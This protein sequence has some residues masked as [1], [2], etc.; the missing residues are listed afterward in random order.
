M[1]G[2]RIG[3]SLYVT[4]LAT[5]FEML[6]KLAFLSEKKHH[7]KIGAVIKRL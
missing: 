1:L 7:L 5:V 3:N 4:E 2:P 6:T